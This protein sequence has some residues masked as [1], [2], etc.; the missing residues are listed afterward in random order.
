MTVD[1]AVNLIPYV[2]FGG[3]ALCGGFITWLG[4]TGRWSKDDW[5]MFVLLAALWPAA[6]VA[7]PVDRLDERDRRK[8]NAKARCGGDA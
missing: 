5:P 7:W 6:I 3:W 1:A 4:V 2:Y 8:R